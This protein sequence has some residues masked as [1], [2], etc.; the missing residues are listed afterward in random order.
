[1]ANPAPHKETLVSNFSYE[2]CILNLF[3]LADSSKFYKNFSNKRSRISLCIEK[4]EREEEHVQNTL[5]RAN[6]IINVDLLF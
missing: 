3:N 2:T 4:L 1:M 6:N 5:G